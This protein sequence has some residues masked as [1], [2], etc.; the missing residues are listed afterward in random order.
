VC[1]SVEG[2]STG[3][4]GPRKIIP[5][6]YSPEPESLSIPLATEDPLAIAHTSHCRWHFSSRAPA[7]P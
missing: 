6:R 5:G 1:I 2:V 4:L 7:C 3:S